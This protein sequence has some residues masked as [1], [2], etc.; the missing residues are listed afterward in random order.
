MAGEVSS[1][2]AAL[3][4]SPGKVANISQY[5][6]ACAVPFGGFR[7]STDIYLHLLNIQVYLL[8]KV[9]IPGTWPSFST[10]FSAFC[11]CTLIPI[12]VKV[13]FEA[14]VRVVYLA[15]RG[16]PPKHLSKFWQRI[17]DWGLKDKVQA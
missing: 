15:R 12:T 2:I 10:A 7:L 3:A 11:L 14:N 8:T 13:V 6:A 4:V 16:L 5:D 17:L 1:Y 9:Q